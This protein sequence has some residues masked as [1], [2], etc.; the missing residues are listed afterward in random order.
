MPTTIQVGDLHRALTALQ[1]FAYVDPELPNLHSIRLEAA[2]GSAVVV[3]TNR[4]I[5]GH[6]RCGASGDPLPPCVIPLPHAKLAADM[7]WNLPHGAEAAL[8]QVAD[9]TGQECLEARIGH[10]RLW[11]PL[12]PADRYPKIE[13][14]FESV[15]EPASDIGGPF[16]LDPRLLVPFTKVHEALPTANVR[17]TVLGPNR[18]IRIE[19]GPAFVGLVMP[20]KYRPEDWPAGPIRVG[21][22]PTETAATPEQ[23]APPDGAPLDA[24]TNA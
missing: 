15:N 14:V 1:S 24:T 8:E 12:H 11:M 19:I 21:V 3:A 20:V 22:T 4:L 23:P 5:I 7:L 13:K 16:G 10:L 17:W 9:E 2:N 6:L 18:P